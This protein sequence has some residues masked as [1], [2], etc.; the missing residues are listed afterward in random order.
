M[1]QFGE[2]LTMLVS[3]VMVETIK[4]TPPRPVSGRW[5]L[6]VG[7]HAG[8]TTGSVDRGPTNEIKEDR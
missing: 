7:A 3:C 6:V 2:R 4:R 1:R 8:G 5:E